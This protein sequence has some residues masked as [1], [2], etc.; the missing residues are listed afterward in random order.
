MFDELLELFVLVPLIVFKVME[1]SVG[2]L[3]K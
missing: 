2:L 3:F 1:Q